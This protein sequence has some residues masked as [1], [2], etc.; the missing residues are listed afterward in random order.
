MLIFTVSFPLSTMMGDSKPKASGT[1]DTLFDSFDFDLRSAMASQA[2]VLQ[3][4]VVHVTNI[5]TR[6]PMLEASQSAGSTVHSALLLLIPVAL[7]SFG[8]NRC[9]LSFIVLT[10]L[11]R[12]L[13][14]PS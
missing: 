6:L 5:A 10:A 2:L 9:W 4:L 8:I 13:D 7:L 3:D 11:P 14:F 12:G 1:L